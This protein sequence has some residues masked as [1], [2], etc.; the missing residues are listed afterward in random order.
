M[1][2]L[3]REITR[4][5]FISEAGYA[6]LAA[7]WAAALREDKRRAGIAR[8]ARKQGGARSQSEVPPQ[9]LRSEHH[10][11]YAVLRGRDWR[12]GYSACT[13]PR[14]LDNGYSRWA[15]ATRAVLALHSGSREEALLAPFADLLS[16]DALA[17]IRKLVPTGEGFCWQADLDILSAY[18]NAAAET[19]SK[20]EASVD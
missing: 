19:M 17:L 14:R 11:L 9:P 5:F 8:K 2:T 15:A 20:S 3:S 13:D 4:R 10:L 7:R 6:Q 16:D 1:N 18:A 12:K